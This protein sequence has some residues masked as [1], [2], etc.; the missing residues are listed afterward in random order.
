MKTELVNRSIYTNIIILMVTMAISGC[1]ALPVVEHTGAKSGTIK[2]G[3][4]SKATIV[5]S[6]LYPRTKTSD[7]RFFLYN[8]SKD[9]KWCWATFNGMA[10]GCGS[11]FS[12]KQGRV[13]IEFD[14]DNI[15]KQHVV[16]TCEKTP[17]PLC[18]QPSTDTIWAMINQMVEDDVT[19]QYGQTIEEFHQVEA[20]QNSRAEA[21]HE[22]VYQADLLEVKRL[23]DEGIDVNGVLR[24]G[25]MPLHTA[26][27]D[28]HVAIAK[29]LISNG[30]D[31]TRQNWYGR[32]PLHEAV[33]WYGQV[34]VAELLLANGADV[35]VRDSNGATPLHAAVT[36]GDVVS[37]KFLLMNGARVDSQN[38]SGEMP[39]HTAIINSHAEVVQLLL[40][41][42]ADANA[43]V[44]KWGTSRRP[45]KIA[46]ILGGRKDIIELL[47]QHGGKE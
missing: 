26:A 27:S 34:G 7:G 3:S 16:H 20:Q 35:N 1:F 42:G 6:F 22:A 23:I 47:K 40:I 17:D 5:K 37:I 9:T 39:L 13:L 18:D 31:V 21:L 24:N 11:N 12:S 30:A 45:I 14:N 36:R 32:T 2:A 46:R 10:G 33:A 43:K 29:L 38:G 28:G 15:V 41:H 4:T 44:K 19:A 8:Y 25:D